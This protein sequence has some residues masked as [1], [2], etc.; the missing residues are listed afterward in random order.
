MIMDLP[1]WSSNQ[2]QLS[3]TRV[4]SMVNFDPNLY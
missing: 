1:D 4:G 2:G 3:V